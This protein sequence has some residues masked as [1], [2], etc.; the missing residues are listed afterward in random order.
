MFLRTF[1]ATVNANHPMLKSSPKSF[2]NN[3]ELLTNALFKQRDIKEI[4]DVAINSTNHEIVMK[5][6]SRFQ[7]AQMQ[8][9]SERERKF[10]ISKLN[11]MRSLKEASEHY[12]KI[13]FKI[14]YHLS[15]P[16]HRRLPTQSPPTK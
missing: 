6:W 16:S 5:N 8:M 1:S 14:N 4:D 13:A 15:A 3:K 9:R 11:A 10:M 12:S 7:M 2:T